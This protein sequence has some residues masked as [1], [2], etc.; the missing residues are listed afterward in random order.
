MFRKKCRYCDCEWFVFVAAIVFRV[1]FLVFPLLM[2][3]ISVFRPS[4]QGEGME[5]LALSVAV[6]FLVVLLGEE[7]MFVVGRQ[8]FWW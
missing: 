5:D 6:E 3:F 7:K 8:W 4:R 1:L 2:S